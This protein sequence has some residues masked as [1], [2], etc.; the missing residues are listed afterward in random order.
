MSKRGGFL[1]RKLYQQLAVIEK[2]FWIIRSSKIEKV[3]RNAIPNPKISQFPDFV[4]EL[5]F[6]EHF[7]V[8]S[9]MTN[10]KGSFHKKEEAIFMENVEKEEAQFKNEMNKNPSFGEIQS[11]HHT[12]SYQ[13]HTHEYFMNSFINTW[14]NH[15][16]S[17]EKYEGIK[18]ISIF[19]IEYQDMA[20]IV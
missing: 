4:S 10:R 15:M 14:N 11:I 16:D 17:Y 6:V 18:K 3:L 1:K 7:Y 12:F 8:T 5:G 19:M 20:I 2:F 13:K 9:S